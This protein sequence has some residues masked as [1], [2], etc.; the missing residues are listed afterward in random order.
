MLIL[1]ICV[2]WPK[3][4]S[5]IILFLKRHKVEKIEVGSF[6]TDLSQNAMST[7]VTQKEIADLKE[8][9]FDV[10]EP[11]LVSVEV[12]KALACEQQSAGGS[13]DDF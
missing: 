7:K 13:D 9:I 10:L 6:I 11:R 12:D 3:R 8:Y 5:S 1:G 4:L 2:I